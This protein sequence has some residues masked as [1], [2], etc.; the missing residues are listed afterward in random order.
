MGL[1]VLLAPIAYTGINVYIIRKMLAQVD[2]FKIL[3]S[4]SDFNFDK[5]LL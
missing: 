5:Q 2:T 4:N 3:A 1:V